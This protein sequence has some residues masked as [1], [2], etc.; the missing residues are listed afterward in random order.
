MRKYFIFFFFVMIP[1]FFNRSAI[2][3][4]P[5][6]WVHCT[7]TIARTAYLPSMDKV[8]R[9]CI[10]YLFNL[11]KFYMNT[12]PELFVPTSNI[13]YTELLIEGW[14]KVIYEMKNLQNN[15]SSPATIKNS[16]IGH[17]ISRVGRV[18]RGRIKKHSQDIQLP[19]WHEQ[20][21]EHRLKLKP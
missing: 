15:S 7:L 19:V 9:D 10:I 11:F 1:L 17:R 16:G 14:Y 18:S 8:G 4:D 13:K 6:R 21:A 2:F 20:D 12:F 3:R 5:I